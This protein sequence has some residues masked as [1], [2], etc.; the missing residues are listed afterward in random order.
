MFEDRR[1]DAIRQKVAALQ[2]AVDLPAKSIV[3]LCDVTQV[4]SA[5]PR[6]L[7]THSAQ[8]SKLLDS[9]RCENQK[10]RELADIL[11]FLLRI[12]KLTGSNLDL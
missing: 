9:Q 6:C 12:S 1:Q 3:V 10:H 7:I 4:V 11:P 5:A 8:R 2:H